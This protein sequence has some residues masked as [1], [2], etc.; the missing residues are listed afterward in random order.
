MKVQ[1]IL[2]Y[3]EATARRT[4]ERVAF[5]DEAKALTFA[6]LHQTARAI[7]TALA[8]RVQ[9]RQPVV[10]LMN[11]RSVQCVAAMMGVLYAGCC[12]VPLDAAL[13]QERL[14]LIAERLQP[15]LVLHDMRG[16]QA[17]AAFRCEALA[18]EQAVAHP[19]CQEQLASI[20]TQATPDD[21]MAIMYTSGSTGIPKGVVQSM[22]SHVRYT[23]ATIEKYGFTANTIFGNQS[24]FFYANSIID[25]FPTLALG[26]KTII[27]P[28]KA[29]AFPKVLI[30]QLNA[31]R[32]I[33]LTMT[34][35]S[36]V[37]VAAS[38]VL[39]A[40]ELPYLKYIVLSG[41]A[42]HWA[43]L[44]KWLAAAPGAEVWNFYGS[45]EL[46]SVAVWRLN[47]A[48]EDGQ[49]IPVGPL[50]DGVEIRFMDEDGQAARVGEPGE[51][52][53]HTP[54]LAEG[55]YGDAARTE[56][57][58]LTAEDGRRFYRS[59]DVGLIN[60][61]NQLV[62]LG[63]K[64]TQIKH[65]GYRMEIGETERA[66]LTVEGLDEGCCLFDK[67][68][69]LLHCFYTGAA[70]IKAVSAALKKKLPRYAIPDQFHHLDSMP[71]TA[72]TKIDRRLLRQYLS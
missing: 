10:I 6:E 16:E 32:I 2:E 39:T 13:P 46:Y 50:F 66:L 41:E 48:F 58:F 26:A 31:H 12:Y 38:G 28:A 4:P 57:V 62:V 52:L 60:Q 34:P 64:D 21:P 33:E 49:T 71:Y 47:R 43:T 25:I 3:L 68:S 65:M 72:T 59:G 9:P 69:G 54:W 55:Y 40:G 20:R 24:P 14:Q 35:S 30:N 15:A 7:G 44:E 70:E 22:R 36:Y 27:L 29:L 51:M 5:V 61:E 63:R 17:A 1:H 45:T 8:G 56:E 23:K 53:I 42:A 18:Y 67:D 19:V 37:K 11:D